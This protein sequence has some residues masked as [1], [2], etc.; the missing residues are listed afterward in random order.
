MRFNLDSPGV[1]CEDEV[2]GESQTNEPLES[3]V[4][5]LQGQAR[6][7]KS[8]LELRYQMS[9]PPR[10]PILCWLANYC[11]TLLSRFQRGPENLVSVSF[12]SR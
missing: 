3:A 8:C 12:M 2:K 1:G 10:H 6:T 4:G 9:F 7:L 5:R 11:G